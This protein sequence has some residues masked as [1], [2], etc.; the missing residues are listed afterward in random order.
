LS[1]L[2]A[3]TFD[4]WETL[5]HNPDGAEGERG[6]L[7]GRRMSAVLTRAGHQVSAADLTRACITSGEAL[8][9]DF[10]SR[11]LDLDTP[12]QVGYVLRA[13]PESIAEQLVGS[14]DAATL[15]ALS[16][17]Y[18]NVSLTVPPKL[19]A[20]V[21]EVLA[22]LAARR[23]RL[24]VICNTGRTP[25]IVLRTLFARYGILDSFAALTFSNEA[26]VRKPRASI[27][28]STLAALGV[29]PDRALHVGDD[30]VTDIGGSK[31]V[32]MRAVHVTTG[33][34][35]PVVIAPDAAVRTTADLLDVLGGLL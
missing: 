3:I 23:L 29:Q 6:E 14:L 25:G 8:E 32:G 34:Q 2:E 20:G 26:G 15:G 12:E 35:R 21:P 1:K 17:A 30:A 4:V 5:V 24:G 22:A 19:I 31:A 9:R 16:A 27:F 18:G 7:R 33:V 11:D 13:L 10:W 28:T